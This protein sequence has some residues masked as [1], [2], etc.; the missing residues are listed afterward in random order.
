MIVV[1]DPKHPEV[2]GIVGW[3]QG[4]VTVLETPEQAENFVKQKAKSFVLC[5]R[6]HITT[7]NFNI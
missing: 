2:E 7:I 5:L 6:R 3:C 4:P 1:G